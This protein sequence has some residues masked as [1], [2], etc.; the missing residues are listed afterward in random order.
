MGSVAFILRVYLSEIHAARPA[1]SLEVPS[2]AAEVFPPPFEVESL[3][4]AGAF[5]VVSFFLVVVSLVLD[6]VSLCFL[7]EESFVLPL[8]LAV[9]QSATTSPLPYFRE[10]ALVVVALKSND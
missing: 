9:L 7:V 10:R 4:F 5:D 2:G 8:L 6:V 1:C 3:A